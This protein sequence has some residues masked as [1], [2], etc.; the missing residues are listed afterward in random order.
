[1]SGL[2]AIG[3]IIGVPDMGGRGCGL[4]LGSRVWE[5]WA[6]RSSEAEYKV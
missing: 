2:W 4:V 3:A 6:G 5:L 1:M